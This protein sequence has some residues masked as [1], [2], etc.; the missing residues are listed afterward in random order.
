MADNSNNNNLEVNHEKFQQTQNQLEDI[1]S[2]IRKEQPLTSD[3]IAVEELRKKYKAGSNFDK[4]VL[5]LAKDYQHVRTIRGDGNCYYRA[6]LYSLCEKL[7]H[8]SKEEKNRLK[9]FGMTLFLFWRMVEKKLT[10]KK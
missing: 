2:E 8:A 7:F 9:T 4:G 5:I 6:F 1:A 3:L 10:R